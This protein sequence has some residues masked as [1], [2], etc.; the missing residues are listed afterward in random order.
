MLG[1]G[2]IKDIYKSI[3]VD[4]IQCSGMFSF[5]LLLSPPLQ[6]PHSMDA[7]RS[8][9]VLKVGTKQFSSFG[10]SSQMIASTRFRFPDTLLP[11]QLFYNSQNQDLAQEWHLSRLKVTC[12]SDGTAKPEMKSLRAANTPA[13]IFEQHNLLVKKPLKV[14]TKSHFP[15]IFYL[16]NS[17]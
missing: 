17:E 7:V 1:E 9:I 2:Q 13:R 3:E 14:H 4:Q 10:P 5:P 15:Q 8:S 11:A 6:L 12:S 16:I